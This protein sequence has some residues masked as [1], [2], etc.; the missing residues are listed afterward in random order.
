MKTTSI[1]L[2]IGLSAL[3]LSLTPLPAGLAAQQVGDNFTIIVPAGKLTDLKNVLVVTGKP[4]GATKVGDC[5]SGEFRFHDAD[6]VDRGAK[7]APVATEVTILIPGAS[8]ISELKPGWRIGS[9]RPGGKCGPGYE[10]FVAHIIAMEEG[11][12]E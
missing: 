1:L 8:G 7:A 10:A 4:K 11:K 12:P 2:G 5:K 6:L 9:F 3:G